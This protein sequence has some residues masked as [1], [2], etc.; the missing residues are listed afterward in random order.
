SGTMRVG[1]PSRGC[2]M[3]DRDR[4]LE[5][6]VISHLLKLFPPSI[7]QSVLGSKD[8]R[9]RHGI[10]AEANITLGADGVHLA[11]SEFH[12]VLRELYSTGQPQK[13]ASRDGIEFDVSI[14]GRG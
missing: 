11:R 2:S 12:A 7:Q 13:L 5:R 14:K 8:F 1:R 9:E 6:L 4:N 10:K 3:T